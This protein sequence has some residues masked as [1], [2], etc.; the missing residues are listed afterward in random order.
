MFPLSF[1]SF[2]FKNGRNMSDD[3]SKSGLQDHVLLNC[4]EENKVARFVRHSSNRYG[5][6][7]SSAI[8]IKAG[9]LSAGSL[10]T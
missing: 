9:K 8:E 10:P 6:S 4:D 5:S 1:M 7:P 3:L 2:A